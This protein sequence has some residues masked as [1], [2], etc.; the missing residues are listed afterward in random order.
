MSK[1]CLVTKWKS[2]VDN[3]NLPKYGGLLWRVPSDVTVTVTM[4]IGC[5]K[6]LTLKVTGGLSIWD[7]QETTNYG[8]TYHFE[9]PSAEDTTSMK[10]KGS[11]GDISLI[12]KYLTW[13][14][15][16][17]FISVLYD[18]V[19]DNDVKSLK[20]WWKGKKLNFEVFGGKSNAQGRYVKRVGTLND[21]VEI[22]VPFTNIDVG[23]CNNI[24]GNIATI[25]A[26][27][28]TLISFS[29]FGTPLSGSIEDLGECTLLSSINLD[30]NRNISNIGGTVEGFVASQRAAGRTTAEFTL[31]NV[32]STNV[33]FNGHTLAGYQN[34][35]LSWTANTITCYGETINA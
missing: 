35:T 3:D 22:G 30:N 2:V 34:T 9:S 32:S 33:T 28:D 10:I 6:N 25:A 8:Q 15:S 7:Y 16:P 18:T 24:T 20:Y 29:S 12:D 31:F 1:N 23:N 19:Y 14:N 11:G 21:L 13:D 27:K 4:P 5:F 26:F 17:R